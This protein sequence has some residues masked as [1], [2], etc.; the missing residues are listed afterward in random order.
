MKEN[1]VFLGFIL[2]MAKASGGTPS[3]RNKMIR[4]KRKSNEVVGRV[5]FLELNVK[6]SL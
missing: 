1:F 4:M 2:M 5:I 6:F 3:W